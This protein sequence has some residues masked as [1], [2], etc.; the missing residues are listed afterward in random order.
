MAVCL[1]YQNV[2]QQRSWFE[3]PSKIQVLL[4]L[5]LMAVLVLKVTLRVQATDLGY[6]LAEERKR[7]IALDMERR[8]LELQLSL[9]LRPDALARAARERIGL[10]PLNPSQARR[11]IEGQ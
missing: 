9:L 8:D 11:I 2:Y 7:T 6:R 4:L 5:I 3:V 10:V 1:D